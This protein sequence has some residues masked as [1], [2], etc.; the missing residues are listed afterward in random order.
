MP[1]FSAIKTS[2]HRLILVP[3]YSAIKT[4]THRLIL[5][6]IYSAIKISTHRLILVPICSAIKTPTHRLI[7]VPTFSYVC[8][9][10][11]TCSRRYSWNTVHL[12]LKQWIYL[13]IIVP[14]T[15][16]M[17]PNF[18][19]HK[20]LQWG[21]KMTIVVW[22]SCPSGL[23]LIALVTSEEQQMTLSLSNRYKN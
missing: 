23:F 5:V 10:L 8:H 19:L 12:T 15:Y 9:C 20:G 16:I 4:S 14:V 22:K 13:S 7:L 1:I 17:Y 18:C 11:Y 2:T 3:I 21:P 6:P